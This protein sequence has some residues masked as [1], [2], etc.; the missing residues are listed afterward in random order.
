MVSR[1]GRGVGGGALG[2]VVKEVEAATK[3]EW[4]LLGLVEGLALGLVPEGL[5]VLWHSRAWRGRSRVAEKRVGFHLAKLSVGI[6]RSPGWEGEG[7][8]TPLVDGNRNAVEYRSLAVSGFGGGHHVGGQV[9]E[10]G[11]SRGEGVSLAVKF[12]SNGTDEPKVNA[13]VAKV[14]GD[15]FDTKHVRFGLNAPVDLG[16]EVSMGTLGRGIAIKNVLEPVY[17]GFVVDKDVDRSFSAGSEVDDGKGLRDLGVLR[18]AVDSGAVVHAMGYAV[19]DAKAGPRQE[20]NGLVGAGSIGGR[21]GPGPARGWVRV[22]GVCVRSISWWGRS[23]DGLG[24]WVS[25]KC[26][27][28][29][30]ERRVLVEETTVARVWWESGP[31]LVTDEIDE[32]STLPC[33]ALTI[34]DCVLLGLFLFVTVAA[35]G[36]WV[37]GG[38]RA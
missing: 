17:Y 37:G 13:D 26:S 25:G 10:A 16:P 19:V 22:R 33:P 6:T 8:M 27:L 7:S 18:E 2:L 32:G 21:V 3:A 35:E 28:E 5:R 9:M 4:V 12:F 34:P 20:R 1:G 23:R 29:I 15:F 38:V 14:T 36:A 11:G 31:L 30:E 24:E